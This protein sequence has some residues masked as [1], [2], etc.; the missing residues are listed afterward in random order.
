[1]ETYREDTPNEF[2][3]IEKTFDSLE[4]FEPESVSFEL[5]EPSKIGSILGINESLNID[6]DLDVKARAI[7]KYVRES[8]KTES[9]KDSKFGFE[10]GLEKLVQRLGV[11]LMEESQK[12]NAMKLLDRLFQEVSISNSLSSKTFLQEVRNEVKKEK[13]KSLKNQLKVLVNS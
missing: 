6:F 12:G 4:S 8:I 1:M 10:K 9:V 13:I 3:P 5:S 2:I 7:D 11:N